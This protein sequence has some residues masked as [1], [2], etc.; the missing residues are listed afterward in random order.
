MRN[1]F[2]KIIFVKNPYL[3][4]VAYCLLGLVATIFFKFKN[5]DRYD[6]VVVNDDGGWILEKISNK[7]FQAADG[8]KIKCT[9]FSKLPVSKSYFFSHYNKLRVSIFLNPFILKKRLTVFFTHLDEGN[10]RKEEIAIL[11]NKCANVLVMNT[12]DMSMLISFG[13]RKEIIEVVYAGADK[14]L[15]FPAQNK[16]VD[17]N[18]V[19]GFCLKY[20]AANSHNKRKRYDLIIDFIKNVD[21]ADVVLVGP[22]WEEHSRFSEVEKLKHFKYY[23][24]KYEDYP[25]LYRQM[26]VFLSVSRLEGGPVPLLEAMMS[27]VIPVASN[28]GFAS[29]I[30][31]DGKNGFLFNVDS[32]LDNILDLSKKALSLKSSGIRES[33]LGFDWDNFSRKTASLL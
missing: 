16:S 27:G 3:F 19:I 30:I 25:D 7:I 32:D 4:R 8:R 14:N 33:V 12:S 29:D 24:A 13:V 10:I 11:L 31:E 9:K 28:T 15:F 20:S 22:G 2:L 23:D 18:P 26:S 5:K 6:L 17:D 1:K 21:F